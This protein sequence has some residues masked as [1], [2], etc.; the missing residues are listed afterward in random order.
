MCEGEAAAVQDFKVRE[1]DMSQQLVTEDREAAWPCHD[2]LCSLSSAWS[3]AAPLHAR[4][5][6][7]PHRQPILQV[8]MLKLRWSATCPRLPSRAG[9][10]SPKGLGS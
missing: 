1:K 2:G 4:L 7:T 9:T 10:R 5:F 8:R 3:T 6:H